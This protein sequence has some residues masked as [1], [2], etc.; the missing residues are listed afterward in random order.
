[1]YSL[2]RSMLTLA[3]VVQSHASLQVYPKNGYWDSH[4]SPPDGIDGTLRPG[5]GWDRERTVLEYWSEV[6]QHD[7]AVK[8]L[9]VSSQGKRLH[10]PYPQPDTVGTVESSS[11]AMAEAVVV[12]HLP[13]DAP[14][15]T[16]R[17]AAP[18]VSSVAPFVNLAEVRC[19]SDCVRDI[20]WKRA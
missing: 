3:H 16:S 18:D 4:A 14:L 8:A 7:T 12:G 19:S 13:G 5:F 20:V 17:V 9:S 10:P 15:Q 6:S 11:G 1:M 2:K